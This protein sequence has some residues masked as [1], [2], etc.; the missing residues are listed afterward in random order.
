MSKKTRGARI[1]RNTGRFWGLICLIPFGWIFFLASII[2]RKNDVIKYKSL[3]TGV[4]LDVLHNYIWSFICVC[5]FVAV[6]CIKSYISSSGYYLLPSL[7][8]IVSI[9]VIPITYNIVTDKILSFEEKKQAR[10]KQQTTHRVKRNNT[11]SKPTESYYD[12]ML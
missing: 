8:Y 9:V 3:K 5:I 4:A 7:G 10:K 2:R 1:T 6:L 12:D 11:S